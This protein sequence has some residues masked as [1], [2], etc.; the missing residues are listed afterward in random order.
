LGKLWCWERIKEWWLVVGIDFFLE[1]AP[2]KCTA[3][4]GGSGC[5]KEYVI[6]E[7]RE[8]DVME[9]ERGGGGGGD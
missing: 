6:E 7:L 8:K 4:I 5:V 2:I 9:R 1:I 3:S